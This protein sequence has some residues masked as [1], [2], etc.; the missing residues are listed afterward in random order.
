M[1][2]CFRVLGSYGFVGCRVQVYWTVYHAPHEDLT[3]DFVRQ[4]FSFQYRVYGTCRVWVLL[5]LSLSLSLSDSLSLS[6]SES[7]QRFGLGPFP[8]GLRVQGLGCKMSPVGLHSLHG[9]GAACFDEA[10]E[11]CPELAIRFGC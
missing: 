10:V 8:G 7:K 9:N 11:T 6:L 2:V 1:C 3:S 5:D 4:V